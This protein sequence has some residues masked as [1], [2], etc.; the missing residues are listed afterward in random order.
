MEETERES[1]EGQRR[2]EHVEQGDFVFDG[3]FQMDQS[4][5]GQYLS[6]VAREE[7]KPRKEVT[8]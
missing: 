7:Y 4:F 2:D 6:G 1:R 5:H 8:R 3:V